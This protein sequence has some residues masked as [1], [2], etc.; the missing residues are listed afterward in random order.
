MIGES[1]VLM[2]LNY[3]ITDLIELSESAEFEGYKSL[4]DKYDAQILG[5]EFAIS[6]IKSGDYKKDIKE[7]AK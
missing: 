2:H 1:G 4:A 7:P 6:L 5:L 3:R